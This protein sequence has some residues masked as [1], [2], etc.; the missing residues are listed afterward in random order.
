M[1]LYGRRSAESRMAKIEKMKNKTFLILL[2][3]I[4]VFG[5]FLRLIDYDKIPPPNEAFDEVFYS[6][7]GS[8]LITKTILISISMELIGE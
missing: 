1:V 4:T 8:S 6:S 2:A 3:L 5:L 7:R